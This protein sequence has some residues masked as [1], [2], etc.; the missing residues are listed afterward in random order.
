MPRKAYINASRNA[1][2]F[3][4][5][6]IHDGTLLNQAV[7]I[8]SQYLSA[9][10]FFSD[11]EIIDKI[12]D[13]YPL[14]AVG[15]NC[16]KLTAGEQVGNLSAS[17]L[18]ANKWMVKVQIFERDASQYKKSD[19]IGEQSGNSTIALKNGNDHTFRFISTNYQIV[20]GTFDTSTILSGEII[21]MANGDTTNNL[22][23]YHN[24]VLKETLTVGSTSV[25]F[26]RLFRS[27][28]TSGVSLIA[29][30]PLLEVANLDA[31]STAEINALDIDTI[32]PDHQFRFSKY[33]AGIIPT[34][35][36]YYDL[37]GGVIFA[38]LVD[39]NTFVAD[40]FSTCEGLSA[41][42][43]NGYATIT[44]TGENVKY[45][46]L[47]DGSGYAGLVGNEEGFT[48]YPARNNT[49][50]Q[51][52]E[53]QNI[54]QALINADINNTWVN[55]DG[56]TPE[57]VVLADLTSDDVT[58]ITVVDSQ[59]TDLYIIGEAWTPSYDVDASGQ[60]LTQAQVDEQLAYWTAKSPPFSGTTFDISGNAEP[61]DPAGLASIAILVSQG[62][63]VIGN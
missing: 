29:K 2:I 43:E 24:G 6:N 47:N 55:I 25:D 62:N 35:P 18:T 56:V 38:D 54:N 13:S 12:S 11:G 5:R 42:F 28:T 52:V 58:I 49:S 3:A 9:S 63:Q 26:D 61:S 7:S 15:Q 41:S 20:N 32:S 21:V 44:A 27:G 30:V 8:F 19:I 40:N 48:E 1:S 31:L 45:P 33:A 57:T 36:R 4:C 17:I 60:G 51:A 16:L 34:S 46:K 22:K 10:P 59:I 50:E 23:W 14:K 37:V 39:N 53:I